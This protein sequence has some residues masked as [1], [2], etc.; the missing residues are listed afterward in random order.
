MVSIV[1]RKQTESRPHVPAT[2]LAGQNADR[3][4][5]ARLTAKAAAVAAGHVDEGGICR[6]C[7]H[8]SARLAPVPCESARWATAVLAAYGWCLHSS[9]A[10]RVEQP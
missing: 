1:V 2:R 9:G 10:A 8:D 3:A 5:L 6:A 7:L 4:G